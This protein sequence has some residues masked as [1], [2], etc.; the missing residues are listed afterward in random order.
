MLSTA[1]CALSWFQIPSSRTTPYSCEHIDA[2]A[3]TAAIKVKGI[4]P[5]RV[6]PLAQKLKVD[7]VAHLARVQL[8][9]IFP[10]GV[11][12]CDEDGVILSSSD[13]GRINRTSPLAKQC[14]EQANSGKP[15]NERV[16]DGNVTATPLAC[17][18][19]R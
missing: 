16:V 7:D 1:F 11:S 14:I 17:A 2:V 3:Q 9:Q 19:E 12:L 8:M 6:E 18:V 4:L 13:T 15:Y 10:E 5:R